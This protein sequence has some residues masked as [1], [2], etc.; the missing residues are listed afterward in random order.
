[1]GVAKAYPPSRALGTD[2][3]RIDELRSLPSLAAAGFAEILS[4]MESTGLH[5][6][7][8]LFVMMMSVA[9]ATGGD[10]MVGKTPLRY[11][12]WSGIKKP[13]V[14]KWACENLDP[15][16]ASTPGN[17]GLLA[18]LDV[19]WEMELASVGGLASGLN[20]WDWERF[21][22]SVQPAQVAANALKLNY[23]LEALTLGLGMHAAPRVVPP[24]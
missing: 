4:K 8:L 19:N 6:A 15:G 13:A 18:A 21:F 17:S 10:R 2:G 11:R 5:A 9:K 16:D 12:I 24:F 14:R 1:M 20:L 7:Q 23:L 3:W 22:D